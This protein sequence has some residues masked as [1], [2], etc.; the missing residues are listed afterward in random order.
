MKEVFDGLWLLIFVSI[1]FIDCLFKVQR[2][3]FKEGSWNV[4][5]QNLKKSVWNNSICFR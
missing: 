2:V 4:G 5:T 3:S 1:F